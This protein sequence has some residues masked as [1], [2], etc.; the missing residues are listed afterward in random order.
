M[1]SVY[2]ILSLIL[3][4]NLIHQING[5]SNFRPFYCDSPQIEDQLEKSVLKRLTMNGDVIYMIFENMIIKFKPPIAY[6]ETNNFGH[7][8][9]TRQPYI[10]T[11]DYK[12]IDLNKTLV[13]YLYQVNVSKTS[14]LYLRENKFYS[15]DLDFSDVPAK[16]LPD[17]RVVEW[18]FDD[19]LIDVNREMLWK[20][21]RWLVVF[22]DIDYSYTM[23]WQKNVLYAGKAQNNVEMGSVGSGGQYNIKNLPDFGTFYKYTNDERFLNN[24][25][26]FEYELA[27]RTAYFKRVNTPAS[28][29]E[30]LTDFR[31]K[32]NQIEFKLFDLFSCR[33]AF[34][35]P[36]QVKG[37]F[38]DRTSNTFYIFIKHFYVPMNVNLVD[39]EFRINESDYQNA[40]N[41][42]FESDEILE[43]IVYE[44]T[45]TKWIKNFD[46]K[47]QRLF[48]FDQVFSL[49]A[50]DNTLRLKKLDSSPKH[51][52][53]R[54]CYNQILEVQK[55]LFCFNGPF[56][57]LHGDLDKQIEVK[58]QYYAISE[59]FKGA[60]ISY[61]GE[62][63]K[64]IFNYA[65]EQ[66]VFVTE[67]NFYVVAY[68]W[69]VLNKDL[70][71]S[72]VSGNKLRSGS[73]CLFTK[74]VN[75]TIDDK[76][77]SETTSSIYIYP[78]VIVGVLLIVLIVVFNLIKIYGKKND[79]QVDELKTSAPTAELVDGQHLKQDQ[80]N[81]VEEVANA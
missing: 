14:E 8:L 53:I 7:H 26:L 61:K 45:Q 40:R 56:Y 25:S 19:K 62:S 64:F 3:Q 67:S 47:E 42:Q 75:K 72:I 16:R 55:Y 32:D 38:F 29:D 69:I 12:E 28:S 80:E 79:E 5:L 71:L 54:K 60:G 63:M 11:K 36:S 41:L 46:E 77:V 33:N 22:L 78:F 31:N 4:V 17:E 48:L 81:V 39:Q 23:E 1:Y 34:T 9:L 65:D 57:Y 76:L 24:A 66:V 6:N 30:M 10:Y 20:E 52:L 58:D 18:P 35:D 15:T 73:N 59:M 74:C 13:G 68:K 44:E 37:I 27:K 43:S 70:T 49:T 21:L 2:L 50:V 51:E